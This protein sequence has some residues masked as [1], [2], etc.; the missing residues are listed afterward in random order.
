MIALHEEDAISLVA[1]ATA[2]GAFPDLGLSD[3]AAEEILQALDLDP[4]HFDPRIVRVS[5][6]CTRVILTLVPPF[7]DTHPAAMP[8][9]L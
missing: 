2:R 8:F 4:S 3:P 6:V 1:C 9:S 7:F 5:S